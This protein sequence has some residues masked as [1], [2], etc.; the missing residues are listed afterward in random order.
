MFGIEL[1]LARLYDVDTPT[2]AETHLHKRPHAARIG[3]QPA[4]RFDTASMRL[5]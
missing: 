4:R 3:G 5:I 1:L 2:A